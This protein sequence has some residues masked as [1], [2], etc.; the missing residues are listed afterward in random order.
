MV[1]SQV[2]LLRQGILIFKSIEIHVEWYKKIVNDRKLWAGVANCYGL[3][4][5]GIESQ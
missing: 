1:Y 4:A 5:R 2:R 3:G